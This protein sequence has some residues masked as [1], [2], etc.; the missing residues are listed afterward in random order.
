MAGLRQS[1]AGAA[2]SVNSSTLTPALAGRETLVTMT[3]FESRILPATTQRTVDYDGG[4]TW[5][6][7][8]GELKPRIRSLIVPHAG[9]G[10][11]HDYLLRLAQ[12]SVPE[13]VR[14][15][16]SGLQIPTGAHRKTP[17]IMAG[18]FCLCVLG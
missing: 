15:N 12:L 3:A 17:S 11:T 10:R 5:F 9:P 8:T 16:G 2:R 18:S 4:F 7:I 14:I 6:R 13:W 1:S